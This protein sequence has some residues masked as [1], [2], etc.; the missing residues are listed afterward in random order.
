MRAV[1]PRARILAY[2]VAAMTALVALSAASGGVNTPYSG[3][4]AGNPLLGANRL[5]DLACAGNTCYAAGDAGTALKSTDGGATWTGIVTGLTVDLPRIRLIGGDANKIVAGGGCAVR[6]SEDG[7]ESFSRPPFAPSDTSC[8]FSVNALAFPSENVGYLLLNGGNVVSTTDAAQTFSRKT[9]VPGS[10]TCSGPCVVLPDLLCRSDTTC[11]AATNGDGTIQRTTDGGGSW[12]QVAAS[13]GPPLRGLEAVG[14]TL[15]AVGNGLTVL[16]STDGGQD[17]N[18]QPVT[19]TP[20]GNLTSVRCGDADTCLMTTEAGKVLRTTDG[21]KTYESVAPSTD[22]VHA[23]D[24]ASQTRA[25]AVGALGTAAISDDAGANWRAVGSRISGSFS[26]LHA[27]SDTAAYA[28]GSNGVLARTTNAGQTWANVSA[29]TAATVT[30]I[31]APTADRVFVLAAD[32]TVQ[33]SDNGG[34][35]YR[36][37]NTGTTSTPR[38]VAAVSSNTVFLVGPVGV[39][40]SANGGET[41]RAST[42]TVVRSARLDAVDDAGSAVV[43]YGPKRIAMTSD[44]GNTW[45]AVKPPKKQNIR[46]VDFVSTRVGFLLDLRGRLWKTTNGGRKWHEVATAGASGSQIEFADAR[47][48]Y[49]TLG[50]SYALRPLAGLLL[51]T[52][53]GGL[54]WHPQLLNREAVRAVEAAGRTDY[55]LSGESGLFATTSRGDAGGPQS[56]SIRTKTSVLRKPARIS[57]SGRLSPADGGE[58]VVV[59]RY[60]GGRWQQQTALVASNG[61]FA[62]R[63]TVGG[64]A[65]FVAQ[66]LGDADHAGTGSKPLSVTLKPK[67]KVKKRS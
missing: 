49:M 24:F 2:L 26:V 62:T 33:R 22:P 17:W 25:V 4:Y 32:G 7:G 47:S 30:G 15:Y 39:R 6:R 44:G 11:F 1:R 57:V 40:Q 58:T 53:D 13:G 52:A 14:M 28:G 20:P 59:A 9:S 45:R 64:T 43:V 60:L 3:W 18:R 36:L 42:A 66:V 35:S 16:K 8:P 27:A 23:V 51:R 65:V 61:S 55:A 67:K 21:G 31:A 48:G 38:A 5:T 19:G 54:T 34:V 56:L 10:A 12:T 37:L 63:W 29:P 41:F 50:S 46:D